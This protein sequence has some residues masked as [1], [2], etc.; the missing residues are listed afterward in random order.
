MYGVADPLRY[1]KSRLALLKVD[2]SMQSHVKDW[3]KRALSGVRAERLARAQREWVEIEAAADFLVA[4][5]LSPRTKPAGLE[6][7][8]TQYYGK[9]DMTWFEVR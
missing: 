8:V 7:F 3:M 5:M 2:D 6:T 4:W 1:A 9:M